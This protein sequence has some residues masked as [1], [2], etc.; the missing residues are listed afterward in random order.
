MALTEKTFSGQ[1]RSDEEMLVE[2]QTAIA[3]V[4]AEGQGYTMFGVETVTHADLASLQRLEE[5]YRA[6]VL[7]ANGYTG[8][9]HADFSDDE[10]SQDSGLGW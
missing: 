2:I 5:Q 8:R 7:L 1:L 10:V 4:L 6:R 9:N 3:A